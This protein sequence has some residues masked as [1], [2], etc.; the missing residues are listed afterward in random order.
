[1]NGAN[2]LQHVKKKLLDSN[3]DKMTGTRKHKRQRCGYRALLLPLIV[4]FSIACLFIIV[5]PGA[6]MSNYKNGHSLKDS[7]G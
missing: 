4:G 3:S 6:L 1:M 7:I 5:E 2:A